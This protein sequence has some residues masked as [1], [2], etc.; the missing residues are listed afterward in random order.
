M[1]IEVVTWHVSSE[2][3]THLGGPGDLPYGR[4]C[5]SPTILSCA[6]DRRPGHTRQQHK[7]DGLGFRCHSERRVRALLGARAIKR[8]ISHSFPNPM[9]DTNSPLEMSDVARLFSQT[10]QR[11]L[12]HT[13]YFHQLTNYSHSARLREHLCFHMHTNASP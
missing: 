5:G 6:A 3:H 2:I 11:L 13:A 4:R 12:D 9:P 8:R 1:S 10:C 7:G